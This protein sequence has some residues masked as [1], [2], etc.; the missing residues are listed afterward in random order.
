MTTTDDLDTWL[1]GPPGACDQTAPVR[2]HCTR[3]GGSFPGGFRACPYDATPLVIGTDPLLGAVI[4]DRYRI[5]SFAGEGGIGRVYLARHTLIERRFA[6]KVP[7][8]RVAT[9]SRGRERFIREAQ[10]ASRLD[11]PNVV[12]VVD[13]GETAAGLLYLVL[14]LADGDTLTDLFRRRS[15]MPAEEV[16]A[17]VR[18]LAQGLDHAH[19]RGLIHRDLKPD[20]VIVQRADGRPRILDFGLAIIVDLGDD[21]RLTSRGTVVGTAH[22]MSPEHVCGMDVDVRTDLWSLGIIMYQA[23]SGCLPFEGSPT[24]VVQ[25]YVNEPVP[26]FARRVHGLAVDPAVEQL[27]LSLASIRRERRPATARAVIDA[28]DTILDRFA[29]ERGALRPRRS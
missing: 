26:S 5:E 22:F 13:F 28:I 23:L 16:L 2:A 10:A 15:A 27:C 19:A 14:E 11:H 18:Q 21:G 20:N 8:G 24:E 6:I 17:L 29:A 3:C 1:S 4:A 25:R 7:S 9:Q 12:S